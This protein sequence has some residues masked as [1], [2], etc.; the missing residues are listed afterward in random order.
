M[1][2]HFQARNQ[3][4]TQETTKYKKT[5]YAN[6]L[7][8]GFNSLPMHRGSRCKYPGILKRTVL[9]LIEVAV[10]ALKDC[11]VLENMHKVDIL[12]TP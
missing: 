5:H 11:A 6:R 3:K 1:L 9:I 10:T 7:S 2:K 12:N 4:R 8:C